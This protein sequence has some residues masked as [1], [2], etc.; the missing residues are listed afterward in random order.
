MKISNMNFFRD[1]LIDTP[2][3]EIY[4]THNWQIFAF[5]WETGISSMFLMI[6]VMEENTKY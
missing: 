5:N 3:T 2:A 6:E 1:A 4:Q